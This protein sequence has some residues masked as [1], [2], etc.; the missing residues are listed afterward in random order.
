MNSRFAIAVPT[1]GMA[2]LA[3]VLVTTLTSTSRAEQL[4]AHDFYDRHAERAILKSE[5]A[6]P[7][8]SKDWVAT[9]Q[10]KVTPG[11]SYQIMYTYTYSWWSGHTTTSSHKTVQDAH[12]VILKHT[13]KKATQ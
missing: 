6:E 4:G 2:L 13:I 11:P 9:T 10:Y 7:N 3:G 5:D 8:P 12:E 1:L